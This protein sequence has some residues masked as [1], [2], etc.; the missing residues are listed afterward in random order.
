MKILVY[1]LSGSGKTTFCKFLTKQNKN[2]I[3]F[4]ADLVREAFD[5]WSFDNDARERQAARLL[6][7]CKLAN[8]Q[9]KIALADFICPF[10]K[11]RDD[12]DIKIFMNTI[13]KSKYADTDKIFEK[14][15]NFDFEIK[16]FNYNKIIK[17]ILNEF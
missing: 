13:N 17:K 7:L 5:D 1:G 8:L 12:Y 15:K 9:N 4:E 10:D 6:S 16:N 3:H 2:L 14:T 11:F